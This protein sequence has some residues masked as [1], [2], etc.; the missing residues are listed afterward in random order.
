MN[1]QYNLFNPETSKD[2]PPVISSAGM[3]DGLTR[4]G[5]P[6]G[7]TTGRSLPDRLP[8]SQSRSRGKDSE[9]K[10]QGIFGQT[11]IDSSAIAVRPSLWESRLLARL[12][13]TGSMEYGLTLKAVAM[14]SGESMF[15]L[16]GSARP[17]S[18]S[19]RI[20]W[21]IADASIAQ[22]G[23]SPASWLARRERL[24][25][26]AR[27]GNGCGTPLA[28]AV[29]PEICGW[30]TP[31]TPSGGPNS[32]STETHT[33]GMDLEGAVQ[34]VGWASASAIDW[35]DSPGMAKEGTNPDGSARDRTDQLARQVMVCGWQTPA[36]DSF[37]SRGGDRKDE[38]GLDQ[39]ARYLAGW[40]TARAED[41]ECCGNH[42]EAMDSL[43]G[44]TRVLS[45]WATPTS[46]SPS[47][48]EYSGAGNSAG[49]VKIREQILG[50]PTPSSD[51]TPKANTAA[52]GS[53]SSK[54]V[55]WLMGATPLMPYAPLSR[56]SKP[57]S[58]KGS[59]NSKP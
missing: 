50:S 24:K 17:T 4:S 12:A 32:K 46:L 20:G 42:P 49:L 39:E 21:P 52:L 51:Q 5:K 6:D 10:I 28:M 3:G 30:P 47:T 40:P 53:L 44:V 34:V 23:E 18:D 2:T 29:N 7:R 11:S 1:D 25:E 14:P 16:V 55:A 22:D 56:C 31:N 13:G 8:A 43:H 33:G 38:M 41:S 9:I 35:K 37:R 15:R 45:G 36:T 48:E 58:R 19:A 57:K 27:N 59:G 26:N 54:F